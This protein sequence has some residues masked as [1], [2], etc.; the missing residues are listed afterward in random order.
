MNTTYNDHRE[1]KTT[2]TNL[3][4]PF[5]PII[6]IF[7]GFISPPNGTFELNH[8]R[9]IYTRGFRIQNSLAV[10]QVGK[11]RRKKIASIGEILHVYCLLHAV[12]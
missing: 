11:Q 2:I 10:F 9:G 5:K 6:N 1:L 8:L 7:A 4:I 12:I 3:R